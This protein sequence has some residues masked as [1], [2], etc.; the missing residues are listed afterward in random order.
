MP[1][2]RQ[3]DRVAPLHHLL[4]V[5]DRAHASSRR[6]AMPSGTGARAD[7]GHRSGALQDASLE[8]FFAGHV[9]HKAPLT[10]ACR[11]PHKPDRSGPIGTTV[12]PH[13][14]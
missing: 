10:R 8:G 5:H 13:G 14:A 4:F 9:F 6:I 12:T 11:V 7:D 1:E 2:I 3:R